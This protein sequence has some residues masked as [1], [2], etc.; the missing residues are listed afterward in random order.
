MVRTQNNGPKITVERQTVSAM[1]ALYYKQFSDDSHK[2]EEQDIHDYA[3]QRLSYCQF[4]EKKP[5]CNVC[6]VHCYKKTYQEQM[7]KIMRYSGPRMLVYHPVMTWKHMTKEWRF[8]WAK[9]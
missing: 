1:I 4:G 3:M 6:P 2:I 5:T 9:K 7:K 8:K